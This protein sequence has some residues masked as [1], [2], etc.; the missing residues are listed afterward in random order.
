MWEHWASGKPEQDR[1]LSSAMQPGAIGG[2]I[3]LPAAASPPAH[4]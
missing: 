3:L 4:R 1:R 2:S